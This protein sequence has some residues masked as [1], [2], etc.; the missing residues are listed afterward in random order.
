MATQHYYYIDHETKTCNFIGGPLIERCHAR[1]RF[2]DYKHESYPYH[3]R[4]MDHLPVCF[5]PDDYKM[6]EG[7]CGLCGRMKALCLAHDNCPKPLKVTVQEKAIKVHNLPKGKNIRRC[8]VEMCGTEGRAFA[9]EVAEGWQETIEAIIEVADPQQ[10][11]MLRLAA[12]SPIRDAINAIRTIC[13]I[14]VH[15]P[16][17]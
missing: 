10:A 8:L 2:P 17:E 11:E 3:K 15:G 14:T 12:L 9:L 7:D 4:F 1:E 13:N 5:L 6:P 16:K